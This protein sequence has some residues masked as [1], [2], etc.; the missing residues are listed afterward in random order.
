[1]PKQGQSGEATKRIGGQSK[2]KDLSRFYMA[3]AIGIYSKAL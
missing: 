1:M 2:P 3:Y